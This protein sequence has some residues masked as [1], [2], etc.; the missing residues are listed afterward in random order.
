MAGRAPC[1]QI[2]GLLPDVGQVPG[3]VYGAFGSLLLLQHSVQHDMHLSE[4]LA[5]HISVWQSRSGGEGRGQAAG[6]GRGGE[7]AP[8]PMDPL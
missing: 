2:V 5:T 6:R 7:G 3:V 4:H 1:R 8:L